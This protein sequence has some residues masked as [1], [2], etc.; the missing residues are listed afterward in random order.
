MKQFILL[1]A[2]LSSFYARAQF[3]N[4]TWFSR[5]KIPHYRDQKDRG[6]DTFE[7]KGGHELNGFMPGYDTDKNDQKIEGEVQYN[8]PFIMERILVFRTNG[9]VTYIQPRDI[10]AYFVDGILR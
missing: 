7:S 4:Y 8:Y 3:N 9:K 1:I 2:F 10:K 6:F 5:S